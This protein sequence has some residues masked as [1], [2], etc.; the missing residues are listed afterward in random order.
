MRTLMKNQRPTKGT[1]G[2]LLLAL[3]KGTGVRLSAQDVKALRPIIVEA[4]WIVRQQGRED[5]PQRAG[6]GR[7]T[8]H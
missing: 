6:R 7:S 2:R 4:V 1:V 8:V 3:M 5:S